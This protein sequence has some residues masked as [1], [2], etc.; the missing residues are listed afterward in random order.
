MSGIWDKKQEWIK[1][2][3]SKS[4][5]EIMDVKEHSNGHKDGVN[6]LFS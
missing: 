1:D 6:F 4:G 3:L 2:V 5:T